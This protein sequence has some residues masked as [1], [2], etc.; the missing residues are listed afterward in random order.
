M[1]AIVLSGA[2][3]DG[4]DGLRHVTASGGVALVQ[5]PEDARA[6]AMPRAAIEAVRPDLVLTADEIARYLRD[7]CASAP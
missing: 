5:V 6:P 3:D 4:A 7:L 2:N 1:L